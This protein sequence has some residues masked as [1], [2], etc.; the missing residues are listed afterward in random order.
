M[1]DKRDRF[2]LLYSITGTVL[3]GLSLYYYTSGDT[4]RAIWFS[5]LYTWTKLG[6]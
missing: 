5:V 4:L 2:G 1:K 6:E 3:I